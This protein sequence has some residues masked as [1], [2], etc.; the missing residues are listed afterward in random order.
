[1]EGGGGGGREGYLMER[2]RVFIFILHDAYICL[3]SYM[4]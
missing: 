4:V 2:E 1:V 3:T